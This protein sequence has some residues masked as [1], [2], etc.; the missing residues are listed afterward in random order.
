MVD[1]LCRV[2]GDRESVR[3]SEVGLGVRGGPPL[4]IKNVEGHARE[5]GL[6]ACTYHMPARFGWIS[7]AAFFV[8]LAGCSEVS[9]TDPREGVPP[10]EIAHAICRQ[11]RPGDIAACA[12]FRL[13]RRASEIAYR[14]CLEYNRIDAR[15]C[16][17]LRHAYEADVRAYLKAAPP[18]AHR[19][20]AVVDAPQP[21]Q[22]DPEKLRILHHTAQEL[23]MATSEDVHTFAAA[24]LIPEV[25]ARIERALHRQLSN[26]DLRRLAIHA[27]AEALYWY[28]YM[29][30]IEKIESRSN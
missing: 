4:Y 30:G 8:A 15:P 27:R 14:T 28:R 5:T 10:S 13:P 7:A 22:L 29:Q 6:M 26:A 21:Q 9:K 19:R 24:R 16:N 18:M 17:S 12:Q 2:R 3:Q 20:S 11:Y 23:Y 25:R 1:R